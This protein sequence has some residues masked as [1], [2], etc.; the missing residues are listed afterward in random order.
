MHTRQGEVLVKV[1]GNLPAAF[2][3]AIGALAAKA[4]TMRIFVAIGALLAQWFIP[5]QWEVAI[6][7]GDELIADGLVTL[8]AQERFMFPTKHED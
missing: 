2:G 3:M 1:F 8:I 7:D 4:A 5:N 6:F